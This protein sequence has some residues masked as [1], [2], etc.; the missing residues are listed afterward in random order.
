MFKV[1][2]IMGRSIGMGLLATS[3][4][5]AGTSVALAK[6]LCRKGA[7]VTFTKNVNMTVDDK[8][9]C[10]AKKGIHG[11]AVALGS[12][13]VSCLVKYWGTC[14]GRTDKGWAP[15]SALRAGL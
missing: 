15:L 8:V 5:V 10:R 6:P 11:T 9:V 14:L 4:V 2:S 7:N 3:V 13:K 12:H 1:V